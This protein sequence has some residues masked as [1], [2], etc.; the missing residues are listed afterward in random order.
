MGY[1]SKEN[2][3]KKNIYKNVIKS[4]KINKKGII[5]LI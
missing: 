3:F 1:T 4:Y 5:E 2:I